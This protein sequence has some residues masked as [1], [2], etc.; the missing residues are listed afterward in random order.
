MFIINKIMGNSNKTPTE[1]K[2]YQPN[3]KYGFMSNFHPSPF[4][5]NLGRKWPTC[6]HFFQAGKHN[7]D[8]EYFEQI[9][10]AETPG[11]ANK[12]GRAHSESFRAD[13]DNVKDKYMYKGLQWKFTQN[14]DLARL[15]LAT[16]NA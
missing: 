11:E 12:L 3:K 8:P 10:T 4:I 6:E 15:L 5:D 9:R 1:I 13:W 7:E 14:E 16:R 2:F